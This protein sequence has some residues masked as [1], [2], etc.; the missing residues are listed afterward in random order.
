MLRFC[1]VAALL[2]ASP[3]FAQ[4]QPAPY[5][6]NP[7]GPRT[8][9]GM[10]RIA[11][12]G[13]YRWTPNNHFQG[14]AAEHGYTVLPSPGGGQFA[15]S[16]GYGALDWIEVTI[17]LFGGWEML[18][19][20]DPAL[21]PLTSVSYGALLGARIA[22]MDWPVRNLMPHLGVQFGPTLVL[23]NSPQFTNPERLLTGYSF[24]AG[25]SYRLNDRF[26]ITFDARL[27]IAR[28]QFSDIGQVN[29]GGGWFS[30]GLEIYFPPSP[31]TFDSPFSL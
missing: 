12:M 28:A 20:S 10:G 4:P 3:A 13:G 18:R 22:K 14:R 1:A 30:L 5:A 27:L 29:A 8:L 6:N 26:G 16:F 23:V 15:A 11:V 19:F 17:D 2:A 25:L 9:D 21:E 31:R 7:Y 24:N